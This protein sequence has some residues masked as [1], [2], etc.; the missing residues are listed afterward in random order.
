MA[1][2][3]LI[4]LL[5]YNF[6]FQPVSKQESFEYERLLFSIYENKFCY[7]TW[8]DK[9][10]RIRSLYKEDDILIGTLINFTKLDNRNW[11]DDDIED[12]CEGESI[13]NLSFAS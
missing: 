10:T 3:S 1:N 2:N 11:Y 5:F 4:R 7:N 9:Y 8:S 12:Y 13:S 6:I